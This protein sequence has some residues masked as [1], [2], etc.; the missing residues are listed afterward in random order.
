MT[1]EKRDSSSISGTPAGIKES[2]KKATT[3]MLV[4]FLLRQKP[5]YTYEMMREMERFSEG[6]LTFN[7]LYIAIY[8]LEKFGYI[9]ESNKVLSEDNRMRIYFS[10]TEEGQSYLE[11]IIEEYRTVTKVVDKILSQD[12]TLFR[13][14]EDKV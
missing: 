6:V 4:L 9:A 7:T 14:E 1:K 11:K 10:I 5:M 8:R 3:E 13:G 2:L 12:G